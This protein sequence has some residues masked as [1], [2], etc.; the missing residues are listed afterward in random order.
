MSK[1]N[2]EAKSK[3]SGIEAPLAISKNEINIPDKI[4]ARSTKTTRV[5]TFAMKVKDQE[6]LQ[7]LVNEINSKS[8]KKITA[9]DIV[10]GLLV[11]GEEIE[12]DLLVNAVH[13]TF[14]E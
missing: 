11:L 14:L 8:S 9:T 2:L 3:L 5:H 10:R 12:H 7:F 1:I 13:K 6:R 4:I